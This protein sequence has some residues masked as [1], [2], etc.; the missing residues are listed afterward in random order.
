LFCQIA[1]PDTDYVVVPGVSSGRRQY[2]PIAFMSA[3]VIASD[4]V[5][6][7]PGA[8]LYHFGVLASSLHNYWMRAVCGRLKSDYRYSKDLVYNNFPWPAEPTSEQKQA[9]CLS[10]QAILDAR[11]KFPQSSLA[12]LYDPDTMP[13]ELLK[14]HKNNDSIVIKVYNISQKKYYTDNDYI[15]S[16]FKMY[17]NIISNHLTEK[18]FLVKLAI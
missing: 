13:I 6:V 18:S 3:S 16:L 5:F 1:Q 11:K 14:A 9:I 8:G 4:L 17:N 12:D 10:A 15:E 7:I 2:V